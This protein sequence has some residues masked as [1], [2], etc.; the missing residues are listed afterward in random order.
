M[1]VFS[2]KRL[3]LRLC[4]ASEAAKLHK[5]LLSNLG[6]QRGEKTPL[7]PDGSLRKYFLKASKLGMSIFTYVNRSKHFY[8]AVEQLQ[9]PPQCKMSKVLEE[10]DKIVLQLPDNSRKLVLLRY[11][12]ERP[13]EL[14]VTEATYKIKA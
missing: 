11:P 4:S 13:E 8:H 9:S 6:I 3:Q 7:V 5:D 10:N 1:N 12:P 14:L 2:D